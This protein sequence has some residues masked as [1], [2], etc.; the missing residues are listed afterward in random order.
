MQTQTMNEE[1]QNRE[2]LF[3]QPSFL[4]VIAMSIVGS[5]ILIGGFFMSLFLLALSA[6][7]LPFAAVKI[8]LFQKKF[9]EQMQSAQTT[10]SNDGVII[11]GEYIVTDNTRDNQ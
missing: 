11:E 5:M 9:N 8:W 1:M 4:Q 6:I 10:K 2:Q 3:K 7:M